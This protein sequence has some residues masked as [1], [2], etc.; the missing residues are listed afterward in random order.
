MLFSGSARAGGYNSVRLRM[1]SSSADVVADIPLTRTV[2]ESNFAAECIYYFVL[3]TPLPARFKLSCRKLRT[4]GRGQDSTGEE[5]RLCDIVCLRQALSDLS[6]MSHDD[7]T[8]AR[9]QDNLPIRLLSSVLQFQWK[10]AVLPLNL[11]QYWLSGLA[12]VVLR[13]FVVLGAPPKDYRNNTKVGVS[14]VADVAPHFA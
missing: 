4:T 8:V 6:N 9:S 5:H 10:A 1:A 14:I 11:T 2:N 13:L 12:T 3:C 7:V